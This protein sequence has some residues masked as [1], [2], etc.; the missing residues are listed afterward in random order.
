MQATLRAASTGRSLLGLQGPERV[1]LLTAALVVGGLV[2][3][4]AVLPRLEPLTG[5]LS[6]PW[7]V[8]AVLFYLGEVKVVHL[9]SRRMTH[10]FTLSDVPLVVGLFLASPTDLVLANVVGAGAGLLIHRRPSA[11]KWAFNVALFF[12]CAEFAALVFHGSRALMDATTVFSPLTWV[13]TF[14]AT[15][16]ANMVGLAAVNA[17]VGMVQSRIDHERLPAAIR[18]GL[19]VAFTNT[20]LA[21]IGVTLLDRK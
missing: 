6:L 15:I 7:W 16:T 1:W 11:V 21:L 5:P 17:A 12:V 14:A 19:I 9:H 13:A 20:A 3:L 2:L 8:L 18:I 10:S 4:A